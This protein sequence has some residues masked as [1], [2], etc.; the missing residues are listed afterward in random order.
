MHH[1]FGPWGKGVGAEEASIFLRKYV[2]TFPPLKE[3]GGWMKKNMLM[4]A[5]HWTIGEQVCATK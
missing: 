3:K 5:W 1:V 2:P 4:V